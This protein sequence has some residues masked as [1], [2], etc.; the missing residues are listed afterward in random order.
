MEALNISKQDLFWLADWLFKMLKKRS[1]RS[2]NLH[3]NLSN[4]KIG[5]DVVKILTLNSL[6]VYR[7]YGKKDSHKN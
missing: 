3:T 5:L 1:F 4:L 7:L 2:I 6:K